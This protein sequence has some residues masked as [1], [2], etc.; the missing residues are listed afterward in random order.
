MTVYDPDDDYSVVG[1]S[2]AAIGNEN[3][4]WIRFPSGY[5][6]DPAGDITIGDV[7]LLYEPTS[8]DLI[9]LVTPPA[10]TGPYWVSTTGTASWAAAQ[11]ET[12]LTGTACASISTMNTNA[13]AGDTVYIRAG[14]TAAGTGQISLSN[15][16]ASGNPIIIEVYQSE[17]FTIED[18]TNAQGPAINLTN[19]DYVTFRKIRTNDCEESVDLGNCTN[20]RFEDCIFENHKNTAGIWGVAITVDTNSQYNVFKDCVVGECGVENSGDDYGSVVNIGTPNSD[21]DASRYNW[22]DNC[23]LYRGGHDVVSDYG[24]YNYFTDCFF[25]SDEWYTSSTY[26]SRNFTQEDH[27]GATIPAHGNTTFRDCLFQRAGDP[28]DSDGTSSI[29]L[30]TSRNRIIR[31]TFVDA[32]NAGITATGP[33]ADDNR[34]ANCT[35]VN[36]G[37]NTPQTDTGQK[38]GIVFFDFSG[39]PAGNKVFN[40]IFVDNYDEVN[41]EGVADTQTLAN[42]W[43]ASDGSPGFTDWNDADLAPS[44]RT[45]HDFTLT[46]SS[47]A[48]DNGGWLTTASSTTSGTSLVVADSYW[49]TDGSGIAPGDVIQLEGS[50]TELTVTAINYSTHTLT[51]SPSASW[52]SGDGVAFAYYGDAPD[53]GAF[54]S[55]FPPTSTVRKSLTNRSG[56]AMGVFP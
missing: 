21:T 9:D 50:A 11:S 25:Y 30:W 42:N 54:E 4:Y 27:N 48:I 1:T 41:Y 44:N 3:P 35:F 8:Q 43:L 13:T 28:P 55:N 51:I 6:G 39:D 29:V 45:A 33:D 19:R 16:G 52:T 24:S 18:R 14:T 31:C 40:N 37:I 53:Q 32:T 38:G 2:T 46:S 47:G 15:D 26:G 23:T 49:F 7:V 17:V 12:A 36:N 20:I 34:I 10:A 56:S 22:F 5:I